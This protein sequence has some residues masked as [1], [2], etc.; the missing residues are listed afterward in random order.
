MTPEQSRILH[1]WIADANH[2]PA[3]RLA[4]VA[5]VEVADGKYRRRTYLTLAA[6]Q[7][8]MERAESR[9]VAASVT[10]CELVPVRGDSE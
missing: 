7:R 3:E 10:L 5:L 4:Y 8:A 2:V 1:N 9:G 6:A